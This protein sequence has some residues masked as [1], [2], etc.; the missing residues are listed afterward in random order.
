MPI[1]YRFRDIKIYWSKIYSFSPFLHIPVSF[2]A[3]TEGS[4]GTLPMKVGTQ[5]ARVR[6]LAAVE[7]AWSYD[8]Q[9]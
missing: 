7:T 6:G 3:L 4:P 5:K 2:E 9:V 1:F 8:H